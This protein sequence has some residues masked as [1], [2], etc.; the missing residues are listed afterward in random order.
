MSFIT[1]IVVAI[2]QLIALSLIMA[3]AWLVQQRTRN[4]GFVDAVWTFGLGLVGIASALA[5]LHG[6]TL[7]TRQIVVALIMLAWSSRLGLHI[8]RRSLDREDDPRYASLI[9]QWGTHAR[10]QMFLLLQKQ[11]VVTLPM[12][13]AVFVA[14]HNPEPFG[15]ALDW[16]GLAIIVVGIVGEAVADRQLRAWLAAK[17]EDD[18]ICDRGL[19]R[20]SRHPNYFFEWLFWLAFPFLAVD[21]GYVYSCGWLAV[22]APVCMYWLL[23]HVSGI[24]P[25]EEHMV[26]K[27]G[28][29]YRAYQARTRAFFTLPK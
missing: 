3:G 6:G 7:T 23:V 18:R 19:W 16:L 24:P 15:R 8:V 25:L 26:A 10:R 12:A 17:S 9:R 29:A 27:H 4:S 11:A 1:L 21:L 14:A 13:L 20:W 5:P 2:L 22:A 28:D